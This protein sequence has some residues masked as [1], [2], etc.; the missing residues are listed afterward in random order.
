MQQK[1]ATCEA[2][3]TLA[4][5]MRKEEASRTGNLFHKMRN[6]EAWWMNYSW[7]TPAL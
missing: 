7:V 2:V 5:E 3:I 1:G 4:E 6:Q